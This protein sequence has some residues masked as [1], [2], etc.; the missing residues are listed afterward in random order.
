MR[1]RSRLTSLDIR[2]WRQRSRT[3]PICKA[4]TG[5]SE[6]SASKE[7][8]ERLSDAAMLRP[9]RDHGHSEGYHEQSDLKAVG[10]RTRMRVIMVP[11]QSAAF[12]FAGTYRHRSPRDIGVGGR[13][14]RLAQPCTDIHPRVQCRHWVDAQ[15]PGGWTIHLPTSPVHSQP[16]GNRLRLGLYPAS[17]SKLHDQKVSTNEVPSKS[18]DI[19][20]H[21]SPRMTYRQK[22]NVKGCINRFHQNALSIHG[23]PKLGRGVRVEL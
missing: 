5:W 17:Q 11:S 9:A 8:R 22:R 4:Q 1:S 20:V 13:R 12:G 14:K 18:H 2:D 19:H 3:I 23:S 7:S 16:N 6:E 21:R 15:T 10:L